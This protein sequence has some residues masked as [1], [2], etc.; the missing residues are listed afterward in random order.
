MARVSNRAY[1]PE[2]GVIY[3]LLGFTELGLAGLYLS[4]RDVERAAVLFLAA[5]LAGVVTALQVAGRTDRHPTISAFWKRWH[6]VVQNLPVVGYLIAF[7]VP[8][9]VAHRDAFQARDWLLASALG[10]VVVSL[11]ITVVSAARQ[12]PI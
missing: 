6:R 2:R 4:E 7:A 5:L 10:A 1:A 11:A 12:R 3:A 8:D 9:L